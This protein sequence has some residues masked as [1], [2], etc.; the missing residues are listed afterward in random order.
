MCEHT[1]QSKKQTP[2]PQVAQVDVAEHV[3]QIAQV[4]GPVAGPE[5]RVQR[6][7]LADV[8]GKQPVETKAIVAG[9]MPRLV[10]VRPVELVTT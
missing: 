5:Y 9:T 8:W 7:P 10:T 1:R 4:D 2:A 3:P 6:V